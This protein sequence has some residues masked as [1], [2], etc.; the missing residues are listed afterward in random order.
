MRKVEDI[1]SEDEAAACTDIYRAGAYP[2][3]SEHPLII[4]K[5]EA[6]RVLDAE[7]TA[8]IVR[9]QTQQALDKRW[10]RQQRPSLSS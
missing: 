1:I 8:E 10:L 4:K 5:A 6:L 3:V 7:I 2:D 9:L